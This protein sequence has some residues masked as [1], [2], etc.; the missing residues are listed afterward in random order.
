MRDI[1]GA[2][3]LVREATDGSV[4]S[5][6]SR[7]ARARLLCRGV[8]APRDRRRG[9]GGRRR[10]D[11]YCGG[12]RRPRSDA[13]GSRAAA[14][15]RKRPSAGSRVV[16][17]FL[18]QTRAGTRFDAS[19]ADHSRPGGPASR[20]WRK[21]QA[22][23]A[24]TAA[25]HASRSGL[26][27]L[28]LYVPDPNREQDPRL[29]DGLVRGRTRRHPSSV[30][31]RRGRGACPCECLRAA[32]E[33]AACRVSGRLRGEWPRR[34]P[35]RRGWR[36]T[37]ACDRRARR[38]GGHHRRAAPLRRSSRVGRAGALWRFGDRRVCRP[39]AARHALRFVASRRRADDG[40]DRRRASRLRRHRT[41]VAPERRRRWP[42]CSASRPRCRSCVAPSS[43]PRRRPSPS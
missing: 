13:C 11:L 39:V 38:H 34:Q 10:R 25:R 4:S 9:R 2:M 28:S 27:A 6:R 5:R 7:A 32:A 15:G 36:A 24:D 29:L 3:S 12:A 17:G 33:G 42:I 23:E 16:V 31:D 35:R 14:S 40:G 8:R 41:A 21:R 19:P 22:S 30:S 26:A 43:G 18:P 20:R 37:G 1:S